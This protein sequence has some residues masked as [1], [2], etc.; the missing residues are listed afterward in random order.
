MARRGLARLDRDRDRDFL[1]MV[2]WYCTWV[3]EIPGAAITQEQKTI[4]T[5]NYKAWKN[6]SLIVSSR[7]NG[8]GS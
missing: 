5:S 4:F 7:P 3:G 1:Q 2:E 6:R 8:F